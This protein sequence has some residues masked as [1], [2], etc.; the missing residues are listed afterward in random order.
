[1]HCALR[2]GIISS[3]TELLTRGRS[4]V[5]ALAMN[6]GEERPGRVP[7]SV[8]YSREGHFKDMPLGLLSSQCPVRVIRGSHLKSDYAPLVGARY[9]GL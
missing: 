4:G 1:M 3:A 2:D 6:A 7:G 8:L 5:T 9:D